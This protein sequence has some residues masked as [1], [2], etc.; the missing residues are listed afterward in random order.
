MVICRNF[1]FLNITYDKKQTYRERT[2]WEYIV[3]Y[4]IEEEK[5]VLIL[6]RKHLLPSIGLKYLVCK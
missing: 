1:I 2:Y 4:M 3:I 5:K 6:T